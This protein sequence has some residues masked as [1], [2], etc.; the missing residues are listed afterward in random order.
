MLQY[1]G[2]PGKCTSAKKRWHAEWK[3]GI[4]QYFVNCKAGISPAVDRPG[5]VSP[6]EQNVFDDVEAAGENCRWYLQKQSWPKQESLFL[7]V[8]SLLGEGVPPPLLIAT[9]ADCDPLSITGSIF[10]GPTETWVQRRILL[11]SA[12]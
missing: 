9:T 6:V 4:Y 7:A 8:Q 5:G 1:G 10:V 2:S 12:K 3:L 11:L